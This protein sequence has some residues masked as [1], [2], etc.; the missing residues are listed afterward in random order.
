ME[1]LNTKRG[2]AIYTK[3]F[4]S[5][6]DTCVLGFALK[7]IWRCGSEN[8]LD[9]YERHV[10]VNHLD[11][12]VG[13]GYFLN[14]CVF[15]DPSPRLVLMDLN[16]NSL[17]KSA[18]CLAKYEP[19]IHQADVLRPEQNNFR[20]FDSIALANLLHCL[21]GNM[22]TK[23][24]VFA[25]MRNLLNPGGSL[26]GNTIL[27]TGVNHSIPAGYFMTALNVAGVFSNSRDDLD[28]LKANLGRHF[29]DSRVR[30]VGSVALFWAGA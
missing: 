14:R 13:T 9:L 1:V 3:G 20:K 27:G 18:Y 2:Q 30:I 4:L 6:Y 15:P 11:V 26:F 25:N 29:S 8:I 28:D 21:P 24:A 23:E 12:G 22:K 10:S 7:H 19:E 17:E 5:V 16:R